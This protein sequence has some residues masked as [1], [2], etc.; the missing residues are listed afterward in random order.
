M[1]DGA[2]AKQQPFVLSLPSRRPANST[3]VAS[4]MTILKICCMRVPWNERH[5]STSDG[6]TWRT[7]LYELSTIT[8]SASMIT[9]SVLATRPMP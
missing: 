1:G 7:A 6:L 5:M 9:A 2:A 8:G 3:G 4:G